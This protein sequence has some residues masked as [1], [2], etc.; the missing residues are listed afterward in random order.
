M[1]HQLYVRALV[2]LMML[3]L[4]INVKNLFTQLTQLIKHFVLIT[5]VQCL[6]HQTEDRAPFFRVGGT[7]LNICMYMCAEHKRILLL[8]QL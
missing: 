1:H 8:F 7:E 5:R 2:H 4:V 3:L 6:L